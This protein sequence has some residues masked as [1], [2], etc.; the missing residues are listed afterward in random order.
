MRNFSCHALLGLGALGLLLGFSGSAQASTV[1]MLPPQGCPTGH[2]FSG[3]VGWDGVNPLACLPNF[4]A[5][6]AGN[7]S[8]GKSMALGGSIKIGDNNNACSPHLA[9]TMRY[10]GGA[11]EGCNGVSWR[12][13]SGGTLAAS[14]GTLSAQ[15]G[16]SGMQVVNVSL[17]QPGVLI[18]HAYAQTEATFPTASA[19]IYVDGG[20][21]SDVTS[22]G[23]ISG[24][25][26]LSGES[27]VTNGGVAGNVAACV[28]PLSS[29]DHSIQFRASL[30]G[31]YGYTIIPQ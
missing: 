18:A 25:T 3:I 22:G 17:Q 6:G 30:Y 7:I 2:S 5:D 19:S 29:G 4:L 12:S 9:G 13:L 10:R 16:H 28:V 26:Q 8:V 1:Q 23:V 11:F 27:S 15:Q 21:C 31:S 20:R 14:Y 24:G